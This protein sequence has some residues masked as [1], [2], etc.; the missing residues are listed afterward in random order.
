MKKRTRFEFDEDDMVEE[1]DEFEE[2]D[3]SVINR[4]VGI[5]CM[6]YDE[7]QRYLKQYVCN[8]LLTVFYVLGVIN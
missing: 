5:D 4:V 3:F 7:E 8:E 1:I 6:F 2:I